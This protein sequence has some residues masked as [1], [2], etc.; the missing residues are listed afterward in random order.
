MYSSIVVSFCYL[1]N[2]P[3]VIFPRVLT[4]G[5][6]VTITR[7]WSMFHLLFLICEI[8]ILL[9]QIN[10]LVTGKML[11][12]K[13]T[14]YAN[15]DCGLKNNVIN[16]LGIRWYLVWLCPWIHSP[17]LVEGGSI[18]ENRMFKDVIQI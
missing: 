13:H 2:L 10:V 14:R 4:L 6:N 15:Y 3:T 18:K 1:L 7:I 9:I 16:I 17:L 11:L 12:E 5:F 8:S